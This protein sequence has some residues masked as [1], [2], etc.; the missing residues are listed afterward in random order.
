ML[1]SKTTESGAGKFLSGGEEI[2]VAH[3]YVYVMPGPATKAWRR[4]GF[5]LWATCSG[6]PRVVDQVKCVREVHKC[7]VPQGI[8]VSMIIFLV[9]GIILGAAAVIFAL[10]NTAIITVSFFTYHFQ[11][12]L[13][14]VLIMTVLVGVVVSLLIVL[15]DSIKSHF[16][17]RSLQKSY[18]KLEEDLRKQKE[19][20][21]FAKQTPATPAELERIDNGAIAPRQ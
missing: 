12:S 8:L 15:P 17:Y 5:E 10:Q 18:A 3:K 21:V 14:L 4:Q 7:C 6:E 11:G 19:L 16:K 2:I 20:T 13:A 9:L 1:G